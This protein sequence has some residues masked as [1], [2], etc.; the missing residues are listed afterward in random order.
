[1]GDKIEEWGEDGW[2]ELKSFWEAIQ[3]STSIEASQLYVNGCT[4]LCVYMHAYMCVCFKWHYHSRRGSTPAR[5]HMLPNKACSARSDLYPFEPSN[6]VGYYQCHWLP[7][8]TGCWRHNI[9][10]S[11]VTASIHSL[12]KSYTWH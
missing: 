2:L 9:I 4:W 10:T 3:K 1:M 11:T 5:H 12:G 6:I 7:F 8:T